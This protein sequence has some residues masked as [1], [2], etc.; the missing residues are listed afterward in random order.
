MS[1][2]SVALDLASGLV[3][4]PKFARAVAR[5]KSHGMVSMARRE[6]TVMLAARALLDEVP[7]AGSNR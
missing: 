5:T 7:N 3:D 2:S 1:S 6:M 4:L